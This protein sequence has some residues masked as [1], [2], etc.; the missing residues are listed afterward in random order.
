M[1][2]RR[3][4]R[5]FGDRRGR[6]WLWPI[7]LVVALCSWLLIDRYLLPEKPYHFAPP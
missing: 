7:V 3:N 2:A 6:V 1:T 4:S 5:R